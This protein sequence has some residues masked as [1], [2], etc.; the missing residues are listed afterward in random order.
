MKER[1]RVPPVP[2][3][4][5]RAPMHRT[6]DNHYPNIRGAAQAEVGCDPRQLQTAPETARTG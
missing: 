4:T 1:G 6:A 3:T 5:T 2:P